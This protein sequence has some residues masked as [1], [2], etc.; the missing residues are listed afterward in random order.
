M[1]RKFLGAKERGE[2]SV[3]LWGDGSP[4]REFLYVEDAAEAIAL[5]TERY[6][7]PEPVN[8]GSGEEIPIRELAELIATES[9]S[10]G[11]SSGT[12]LSRMVSLAAGW[13]SVAQSGSSASGPGIHSRRRATDRRLVRR[14][15]SCARRGGAD[16]GRTNTV[17]SD[18]PR[19]TI[20]TPSYNQGEFLEQTIVS[21]LDQRYPNLEYIVMDGGS[22][23]KSVEIIKRYS[24]YLAHWVSERDGGSP[25][26]SIEASSSPLAKFSVG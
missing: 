9:V 5:A 16:R 21:V 14:A 7:G 23:D 12:R 3:V 24:K 19:I 18:H 2:P 4:T 11:R 26:R 22:A 10:A 25:R 6:D 13:T 17:T 15:S 8:L 20:V 1:I